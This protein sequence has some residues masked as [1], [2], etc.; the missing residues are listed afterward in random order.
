MVYEENILYNN[1]WTILGQNWRQILSSQCCL[2]Q[3]CT[4]KLLVQFWIRAHRHVF[5][6]K[7]VCQVVCLLTGFNTTTVFFSVGLG[8]HL[9]FV[10][11]IYWNVTNYFTIGQVF[12]V[13]HI[14]W[15]TF[16][17]TA[18]LFFTIF[19]NNRLKKSDNHV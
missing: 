19:L 15:P 2:R 1:V 7:P 10:I 18:K 16:S 11:W 3:P 12:V 13:I 9:W 5:A 8:V 6:G 4:K 17:F 14:F